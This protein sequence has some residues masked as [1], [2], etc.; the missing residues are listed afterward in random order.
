[1]AVVQRSYQAEAF[2]ELIEIFIVIILPV[3][4][5]VILAGCIF[6]MCLATRRHK[7][8]K[9]ALRDS[10]QAAI[11]TNDCI[12][13]EVER[14]MMQ[15]VPETNE[16][17]SAKGQGMG[18]IWHM[19]KSLHQQRCQVVSFRAIYSTPDLKKRVEDEVG[20]SIGSVPPVLSGH[21]IKL[22]NQPEPASRWRYVRYVAAIVPW[23]VALFDDDE[24]N[25]ANLLPGY[26]SWSFIGIAIFLV[27]I[28]N[29]WRSWGETKHGRH[30]YSTCCLC[31]RK[32]FDSDEIQDN[33]KRV[34]DCPNC[35]NLGVCT[36]DCVLCNERL[37]SRF[38][39]VDEFV[40]LQAADE[41]NGAGQEAPPP[42][43]V[44]GRLL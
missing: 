20:S 18:P 17:D 3:M 21:F 12:K 43:F 29:A 36:I 16:F 28:R 44:N 25:L 39:C 19:M 6:G 41:N 37:Q 13:T 7:R 32:A 42:N 38:S 10:I 15:I 5:A 8:K 34:Q 27:S 11:E 9:E 40:A 31:E 22:F 14:Q 30:R 35:N 23:I 1:M 4:L 33:D 24:G 2:Q 26:F